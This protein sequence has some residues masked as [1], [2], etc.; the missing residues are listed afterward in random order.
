MYLNYVCLYWC[1]MRNLNYKHMFEI[2]WYCEL[3]DEWVFMNYTH[4]ILNIC[5]YHSRKIGSDHGCIPP[6]PSKKPVA[7]GPGPS[8][9]S[10]AAGTVQEPKRLSF[11]VETF[12]WSH[13]GSTW[14]STWIINIYMYIYKRICI[15]IIFH[16]FGTWNYLIYIPWNCYC[17]RCS[18]RQ[19]AWEP[20]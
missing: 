8:P 7:M 9:N 11:S 6:T 1:V 15:L 20:W 16:K 2:F 19:M 14:L 13:D 17:I 10:G 12:L 4:V 3:N 5:L 18:S